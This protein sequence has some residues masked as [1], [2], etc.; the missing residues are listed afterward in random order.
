MPASTASDWLISVDDHVIEPTNVWV[1]RLPAKFRD[2]GP[3]WVSD[4][5]GESWLF[6][7]SERIPVGGNT[8]NGA[9]WPMEERSGPF[10]VL[11]WSEV[12]EACYDPKARVK[13]MDRHHEIAAVCFPNMA[14]FAGS[15]FQAA[16]DKE[17]ALLCIQAYNDWFLEEWCAAAPGR[18]VGLAMIPMWDGEL[19]AA[20]AERAINKGARAVT[21]SMAPQN[22]GFPPITDEHWHPLFQLMNDAELPLCTHLGSGIGKSDLD[23]AMANQKKMAEAVKDNDI[24]KVAER[25]GIAQ[26]GQGNTRQQLPGASTSMIGARMG[27]DTVNDWLDS[28][29]F[30]KYPNLKVSLSENGV[31][32]IP[33]VLSLQDWKSEMNRMATVRPDEPVTRRDEGPLPSEVFRDH[34]YGCFVH[35]PITPELL[36]IV[37]EDNVMIETDYPHTA[38]NFPFSLERALDCIAGLPDDVQSKILRG[39]AERVF[40]FQPAEPPV[41][42]G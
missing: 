5:E 16:D 15:L 6:Q 1:D 29:M 13:A 17:L 35:E 37:G 27:T 19:A 40:N 9:V 42:V 31:G 20:E 30:E 23:N 11:R 33:S 24:S 8:T 25:F 10:S 3:R 14:G 34:M 39:T 28:A 4:D 26:P 7:E 2:V 22:I 36:A 12:P 18:F 32:W 41:L 38:T 21:F